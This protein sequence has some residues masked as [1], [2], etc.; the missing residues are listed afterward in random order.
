MKNTPTLLSVLF[1]LFCC[2]IATAQTDN[3]Q[4]ILG[5]W[6]VRQV[7][8]TKEVEDS[9]EISM[10]ALGTIICFE[11][12]G[13][14]IN[15]KGETIAKGNYKLSENGRTLYQNSESDIAAP[16]NHIQEDIPGQIMML[17][18]T[19]LQIQAQEMILY[20]RRGE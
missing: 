15:K 8:F 4:L 19:E 17:S 7:I 11:K 14:F 18:N 10:E 9:D 16:S 20:F 5:C 3:K 12:D 6:E 13:K 1:S 2:S